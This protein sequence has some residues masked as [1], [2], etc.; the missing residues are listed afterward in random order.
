MLKTPLIQ[1]N[2]MAS[3]ISIVSSVL[4]ELEWDGSVAL[5]WSKLLSASRAASQ[6]DAGTEVL[7]QISVELERAMGHPNLVKLWVEIYS[8]PQEISVR[9]SANAL[10]MHRTV[11][12]CLKSNTSIIFEPKPF[13]QAQSLAMVDAL[14]TGGM[15]K[16]KVPI[17]I[18]NS[19]SNAVLH[20]FVVVL[21]IRCGTSGPFLDIVQLTN[22]M[23]NVNSAKILITSN[24]VQQSS[25]E[26]VIP[27]ELF[28]FA[29]QSLIASAFQN[30]ISADDVLDALVLNQQNLTAYSNPGTNG[31][32]PSHFKAAADA[33][34]RSFPEDS[35]WVVV[36]RVTSVWGAKAFVSRGHVTRQS[37]FT[38]VL[39]C[40]LARCSRE[41]LGRAS[42]SSC[43]L[44]VELCLSTGISCY[45]DVDSVR[46]RQQGM[47]VA[48]A[49]AALLGETLEFPEIK[50]LEEEEEE[51]EQKKQKKKHQQEEGRS[52]G[53]GA[54]SEAEEDDEED[55]EDGSENGSGGSI[56]GSDDSDNE[57][58]GL[59][60]GGAYWDE[61]DDEEEDAGG[62]VYDYKDRM[63]RTNYLR[64]CLQSKEM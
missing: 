64:D 25:N 58:L 35:L 7:N 18:I 30:G 63:L 44:P 29:V 59:H 13:Y 9:E 5:V 45:L 27:K 6:A 48:T 38:Q 17:A 11:F 8:L 53:G 43:G 19:L 32:L 56:R 1:T 16:N 36:D 22:P 55:D 4:K 15:Y 41:D 57:F 60:L 14:L 28:E 26:Y 62:T 34:V 46:I 42:A 52:G 51:E 23:W 61:G 2:I 3:V 12:N 54:V 20:F 49:Y 21:C 33:I 39:L 24:N 50:S 10:S 47:R 37:F 31:Y 40:A